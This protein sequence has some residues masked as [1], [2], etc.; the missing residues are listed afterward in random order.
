MTLRI[1][2][3]LY[4]R[5]A[6]FQYV[7]YIKD[8]GRTYP[9]HQPIPTS[10]SSF[11]NIVAFLSSHE[12]ETSSA[13]LYSPLL[14]VGLAGA[15]GAYRKVH[16]NRVDSSSIPPSPPKHW[17]WGNKEIMG[18][19]YRHVLLGTKYK[20][21][22]GDIISTTTLTNTTIYL[23]TIELATEFLEKHTSVTSDRPRDVMS[24]D[25]LGWATSAAFRN[26]D[27]THKKMRRVLAS[28]LHP[29]AAR[30]Y[31]P[32]HVET[33]LDLLREV[34]SDPTLFMESTNN[35]VATFAIRLAYGYTP[36]AQKDPILPLAQE[37]IRYLGISV[38]NYW[39]VNDFPLLKHIPSWLPGAEFQRIGE[40]GYRLR[41][42][43]ADTMFNVVQE[44]VVQGRVEQPSYVSGLLESKGGANANDDDIYLI[45]YTGASIFSAGASTTAAVVKSFFLMACLY[46]EAVKRAQAEIDSVVGRERIPGLPD[47]S[48]L[49]YTEALVQE[50]MRM[51]PPA[52]LGLS[53]LVTEEF[54]FHGYRIPK[55]AS[56]NGNI[57]AMLRDPNHFVSP[58]TFDPARFMGPN[59]EPDPR[60]YIFGFGRRVCPG[61]HVAN[62]SSWVM[63]AG[64]LSVFN[65]QPGPQ[66]AAKVASLGGR[67]SE[68]LYELT[69]PYGPGDPLPFDC[70]LKPRDAAAI[71]LLENSD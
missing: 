2:H 7:Q 49:P 43:Y 62:N 41:K 38:S 69:E 45:K 6:N 63:C 15:A 27:E 70:E 56:V 58:H 53:H 34:A 31:G 10:M 3:G 33:T 60:K 22:L 46:P 30:S 42:S 8:T 66:L 23:N 64:L 61:L 52:P 35:A 13:L 47:R 18:K 51:C 39:L 17:L 25:I 36:K 9:L 40:K 12:Y 55:G 68:K 37:S 57:W 48:D 16:T 24:Q 50:V 21:E 59:P 11:D 5:V 54:E 71:S 32:Q 29:T 67:E 20:H 26:H 44:Q 4:P 65:F 19:P 14:L 28:A 1:D